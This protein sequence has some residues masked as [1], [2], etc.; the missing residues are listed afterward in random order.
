MQR[1]EIGYSEVLYD[2][3]VEIFISNFLLSGDQKR[4]KREVKKANTIKA[5]FSLLLDQH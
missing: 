1:Q 5:L 2:V 4:K 3:H